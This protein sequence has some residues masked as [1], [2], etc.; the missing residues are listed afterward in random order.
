MVENGSFSIKNINTPTKSDV[1]VTF[2]PQ[3]TT[4]KYIYTIYDGTTV[5]KTV[6]VTGN[7]PTNIYLNETGIYRIEVTLY[8]GDKV[9]GITKSGNYLI[10]KTAPELDVG[11]EEISLHEGD[12]LLV[13]E[14]I[15][16]VDN[17]DGEITGKITSNY[18]TIDLTTPGH[19]TLIYTVSDRAGNTS[20]KSVDINVLEKEGS[21]FAIQMVIILI[22][23][24][25]AYLIVRFRKA[26]KYEKRIAPFTIEPIKDDTVGLFERFA[27]IYHRMTGFLSKYLEKSVFMQKYAKKLD[28]YAVVSTLNQNGMEI[29]AGKFLIAFLF[30]FIAVFSKT[31]QLKLLNV[32]E[33]VIPLTIGFMVL[34]VVYFI[35]YKVFRRKLEND[36]LSAIIVMNNAFKSGR[37]ISQAIEIVSKEIEGPIGK[38]FNKMSLELSYGL[39]V[40]VI[41]KR[42]AD[43][44]Q[45]EEVSYL[46]ASLSILNKTGGNIVKVFSSI[47]KN[48]FNKK[49]LRLELESL[50]GSSKLIVYMLF[51]VPF[52][53]IIFVSA[54]SPTYFFPFIT[55]KLGNA[56]L[57]GMLIY[58]IIFIISV[59]KIMKVVI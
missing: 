15:K 48:L 5:K 42:F 2:S 53:F 33:F 20:S 50:T 32:Y 52:L 26:M 8:N 41:F 19:K 9:T 12:T 34:D 27:G 6:E 23:L 45:L 47:E 44:V 31:I 13:D 21:L 3:S 58:Y 46:T 51:A 28:K 17:F 59:R 16:A 22:L 1:T 35:K 36:L 7:K 14:G 39:S 55:S 56:L 38:E 49:K 18:S 29:L 54:I 43:R 40:D 11:E 37:S 24:I 25:F 4:T 57:I 10:D 30:F